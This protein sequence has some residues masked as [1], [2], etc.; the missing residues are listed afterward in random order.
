[1]TFWLKVHWAIWTTL[2]VIAVT[3]GLLDYLSSTKHV[4]LELRPN[5]SKTVSVFRPFPDKLRL[6]L[7]FKQSIKHKRPEHGEWR[8]NTDSEKIGFLEF[9]NPGEPIKLLVSREGKE[10][11]YEALPSSSYGEFDASRDLY[12]FV[13][14]GNPHHFPW[15]PNLALS[16]SIPSGTSTFNISVLEVGPQLVG[17]QVSLSIRSPINFKFIPAATG[18]RFL[19][20]FM[21]WP[22]YALILFVYFTILA[23]KSSPRITAKKI[24]AAKYIKK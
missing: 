24:D 20:W 8:T 14:D 15:P 22:L 12:P 3:G 4:T 13:E 9:A 18:Y 23:W 6:G 19:W 5:S 7:R 16:Q 10:V 11:V 21:F 1:M 17:E 2:V